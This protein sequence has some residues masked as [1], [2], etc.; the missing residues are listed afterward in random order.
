MSEQPANQLADLGLTSDDPITQIL[1]AGEAETAEEAEKLYLERSW[2]E[3]LA[4]LDSNASQDELDWH[5]LVDLLVR[6]GMRGWEDS[7]R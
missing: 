4:F 6:R 7:L 2:P 3:F 5:P 1:L